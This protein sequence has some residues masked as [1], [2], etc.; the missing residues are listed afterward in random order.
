MPFRSS[1][2]AAG[3]FL[4]EG[5]FGA[6]GHEVVEVQTLPHYTVTTIEE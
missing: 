1:L 2:R 4:G 6:V 3:P 5:L